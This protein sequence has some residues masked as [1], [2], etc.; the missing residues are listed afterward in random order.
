[1]SSII[2]RHADSGGDAPDQ[3]A[4][5]DEG[6]PVPHLTYG[7]MQQHPA[8]ALAVRTL[9]AN[10]IALAAADKAAAG[11]FR[12][13]GRYVAAMCAASL[14]DEGITLPRVKQL[15]AGF[16]ILSAGR[17]RALLIYL[18]Y[19]GYVRLWRE[20]GRDGP[21]LYAA[22]PAF[23]AV[24][25]A[26]LHAALDAA[27]LVEPSVG[28]LIAR[29]DDPMIFAT[30][31]R[32]QMEGLMASATQMPTETPFLRIFLQRYGG[33]QIAWTLLLQGDEGTHPTESPLH[34]SFAGLSRDFGVS[35]MHVKRLFADA[36]SEGLLAPIVKGETR[37]TEAGR[38]EVS[39]L[40]AAQLVRLLIASSRTLRQAV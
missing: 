23:L 30:L 32:V 14:H 36:V 38:R 15:C 12:D 16:G 22:S 18:R 2:V 8:F 21:A 4:S 13:A 3:L 17:A 19:L 11:I 25:R 37:F 27:C 5:W 40:Y 28:R 39:L 29:L 20:R 1:M 31:C 24:W 6:E 10:M 34:I 35:S 9:A 7:R 26:H 33:S